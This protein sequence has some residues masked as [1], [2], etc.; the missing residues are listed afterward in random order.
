MFSKANEKKIFTLK[1]KRISK[2]EG[3]ILSGLEAVTLF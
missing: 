3:E 2:T 1:L